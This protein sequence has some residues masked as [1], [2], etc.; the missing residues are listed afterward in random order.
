MLQYKVAFNKVWTANWRSFRDTGYQKKPA[1]AHKLVMDY[2]R[3]NNIVAGE[4]GITTYD[5]RIT[6]NHHL[7]D[8]D[9]RHHIAD[10]IHLMN[11]ARRSTLG[12][13]GR[14]HPL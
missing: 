8:P 3:Q 12:H 6:T 5:G 9:P 13:N 1:Q 14:V 2:A 11:H 4:I 7:R 10:R